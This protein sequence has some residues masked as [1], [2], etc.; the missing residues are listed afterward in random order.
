MKTADILEM[1]DNLKIYRNKWLHNGMTAPPLNRDRIRGLIELIYTMSGL[2]NPKIVWCGSPLETVKLHLKN[3]CKTVIDQFI[4]RIDPEW[5]TVYRYWDDYWKNP[6]IKDEKLDLAGLVE[7]ET[8]ISLFDL[9]QFLSI[10]LIENEIHKPR[11]S[12]FAESR[13][14]HEKLAFCGFFES[15]LG[16]QL[17][18]SMIPFLN[19][20]EN[21]SWWIPCEEEVFVS[22]NPD[23]AHF[24][25]NEYDEQ[26]IVIPVL[27]R[28]GGPALLYPDGFA[29]Y[30][31]NGVRV[32]KKIAITPHAELDPRLILPETHAE[33]RR[34][35]VR[36]I[37]IERV[38]RDLQAQVIDRQGDYELLILDIGDGRKRPYLKM[39]NPSIGV[40]H[41]EGVL[42]GITT[43]KRAL[44]WR[45]GTREVPI[46]IR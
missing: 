24:R 33:A 19:L 30:A 29:V 25:F 18:Y 22:E 40:Y 38:C 35:I 26:R 8:A 27:H 37:G 10:S 9:R 7:D 1:G 42:P 14:L 2:D 17:Q 5:K 45:N 4:N 21:C 20:C 12:V 28:D 36:K 39:K 15:Q 13:K 3:K 43:V 11:Y 23:E 46:V 32:S 34:E 31:L 16:V 44:E 6:E 41:I